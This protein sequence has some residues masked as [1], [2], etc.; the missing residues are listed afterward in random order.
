MQNQN[1]KNANRSSNFKHLKESSFRASWGSQGKAK[2]NQRKG[3]KDKRSNANPTV[4]PKGK[5]S[6]SCSPAKNKMYRA[7]LQK[8]SRLVSYAKSTCFT[9]SGSSTPYLQA[10]GHYLHS[11]HNEAASGISK[12]NGNFQFSNKDIATNVT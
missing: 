8:L 1:A 2:L 7:R 10:F 12:T 9:R 4:Y 3:A 11:L 5:S 6:R